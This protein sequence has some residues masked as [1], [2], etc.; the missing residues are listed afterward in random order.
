MAKTKEKR[1]S[2]SGRRGVFGK[3]GT[4]V[5]QLYV[6][7]DQKPD[8]IHRTLKDLFP[9]AK[10]IPSSTTIERWITKH[11]WQDDRKTATV[12]PQQLRKRLESLAYKWIE[13]AEKRA[14]EDPDNL[15][16]LPLADQ[17]AKF[18]KWF[19]MFE[20]MEDPK[21]DL[22]RVMLRFVPFLRNYGVPPEF[23]KVFD[24]VLNAYKESL[25]D[26]TLNP[27]TSKTGYKP[28]WA[29]ASPNTT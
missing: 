14:K 1:Q 22:I 29:Q 17:Y 4:F 25:I 10:D 16:D 26:H 20:R 6:E 13:S 3:Y 8:D 2:K 7:E 28:Q 11:N 27:K 18:A 21:R 12:S 5:W 24:E 19:A 15:I 23:V 9:S